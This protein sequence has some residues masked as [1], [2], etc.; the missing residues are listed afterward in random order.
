MKRTAT[1]VRRARVRELYLQENLDTERIADRLFSEGLLVTKRRDS[2]MRLIRGDVA[3]VDQE[4][5]DG[6]AAAKVSP[7]ARARFIA[8]MEGLYRRLREEFDTIEGATTSITEMDYGGKSKGTV[9]TTK[10]GDRGGMRIRAAALMRDVAEQIA[11]AEGFVVAKTA[12]PPED[13]EGDGARKSATAGVWFRFSH[14]EKMDP[15]SR[16]LEI[17][18]LMHQ[19]ASEGESLLM[20]DVPWLFSLRVRTLGEMGGAVAPHMIAAAEA[21]RIDDEEGGGEGRLVIV[22]SDASI[23]SLVDLNLN[24]SRRDGGA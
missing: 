20:I 7:V 23:E 22:E 14:L 11:A 3:I 19:A 8:R 1:A 18:R 6:A 12:A 4:I 13:E 5:R 9:K 17:D 2:A 21:Q 10:T 16:L 15:G 24:R